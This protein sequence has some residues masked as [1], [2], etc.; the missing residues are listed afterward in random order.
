SAARL[1]SNPE[2]TG[3]LDLEDLKAGLAALPA[4]Q[5]EALLLV[6]ASG[7][8]YEDA[9]RICGCAIGT[10]K[11]RVNRARQKLMAHLAVESVS[12]FG[13]DFLSVQESGD[14]SAAGF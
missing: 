1:F 11:S 7:V 13:G 9:A 14:L 5:R 6:G 3:H 2:Q 12:E 4:E 8:S 10:I